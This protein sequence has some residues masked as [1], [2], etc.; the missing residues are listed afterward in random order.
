MAAKKVLGAKY[1][2]RIIKNANKV[3]N[4]CND[5]VGDIAGIV[6]GG[7]VIV[8]VVHLSKTFVW[9]TNTILFNLILTSIVAAFTIGGKAIGKSI[10]INYC[11]TIVFLCRYYLRKA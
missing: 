8:F 3:S 2:L 11:N 1:A 10:A 7:T 6:S 9:A 4:F 5:V